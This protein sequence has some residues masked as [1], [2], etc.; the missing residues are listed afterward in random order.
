VA[1][2]RNP[3]IYGAT[4]EALAL[5]EK[6]VHRGLP[7][8]DIYP[9]YHAEIPDGMVEHFPHSELPVDWRSIYP[10]L[11]TQRIGDQ[12]LKSKKSL[13]LLVP[14]I[15]IT[16]GDGSRNCILNPMVRVGRSRY[17]HQAAMAR[18]VHERSR[19]NPERV[20]GLRK[21]D[22]CLMT[23]NRK[24]TNVIR[25]RIIEDLQMNPA[26]VSMR[27]SDG[28]TMHVKVMESNNSPLKSVV[29]QF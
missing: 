23:P 1:H 5:L 28:S 29:P 7:G 9:L 25:G 8:P 18:R 20:T 15:L 14:S 6:L 26:E 13:V 4:S 17:T 21:E 27:F 2:Q 10:P 3:V 24:L 22:S 19:G 16:G 11:S 12:W